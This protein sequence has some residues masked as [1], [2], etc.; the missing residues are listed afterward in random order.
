MSTEDPILTRRD[1]QRKFEVTGDTLTR[2]IR[3]KRIPRPDIAPT[4]KAQQWRTSTLR[5]AGVI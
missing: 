4:R 3:Q 1:L 5:A 2:W